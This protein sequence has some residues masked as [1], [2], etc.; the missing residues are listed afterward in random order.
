MREE[1]ACA[2][3]I[4]LARLSQIYSRLQYKINYQ[5]SLYQ[6]SL[7]SILMFLCLSIKFIR[8]LRLY[9]FLN[10]NFNYN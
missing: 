9:A 4:I 8:I 3:F 10:E 1:N 5:L 7:E 2:S 6:I